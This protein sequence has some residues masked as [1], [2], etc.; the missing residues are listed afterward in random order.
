MTKKLEI[1]KFKVF[2]IKSDTD[3]TNFISQINEY[4][5]PIAV[6]T[7]RAG[8][9]RYDDRAYLIQ[10]KYKNSP[11]FLIDPVEIS[12]DALD[13]LA[14][15]FNQETW[16]IH[17]AGEDLPCLAE[18]GMHPD[19]LFDTELA[20]R[21]LNYERTALG[22]LTENLLDI[23]L[24]KAYS[25]VDWSTR[26]L[27]MEWLV[28]AALDVELLHKLKTKLSSKLRQAKKTRI[29][30]IEF[31][32]LKDLPPREIPVEPWRKV[33]GLGK[34]KTRKQLA[35]AREL[36][37]VRDKLARI[38]DTAPHQLLKDRKLVELAEK[39]PKTV[40]QLQTILRLP[41][42]KRK[43]ANRWLGAIYQG[44]RSRDLPEKRVRTTGVPPTSFWK[45]RDELTY[46]RFK[47]TRELL[48]Q[49]AME[50]NL[51]VEYLI[52]PN[53]IKELFWNNDLDNSSFSVKKALKQTEARDWQIKEIALLLEQAISNPKPLSVLR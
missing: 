39:L 30:N 25:N 50:L 26:P 33:H 14:F 24:A 6:D 10:I 4:S 13:E 34:L 35:V 37:R 17:A 3:V 28:Y 52:A 45:E 38:N 19:K 18:L 47:T 31:N 9:F 15:H 8:S 53:I 40:P 49:K 20:A 2:Y 42:Y 23:E 36:W 21:L 1:P 32:F 44:L 27:P 12:E 46:R 7:E 48:Q 29:A 5:G 22:Y 11:I 43:E 41:K 51:P 16:I